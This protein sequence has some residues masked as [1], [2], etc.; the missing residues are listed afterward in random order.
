VTELVQRY[1]SGLLVELC[2][3]DRECEVEG[4]ADDAGCLQEHAGILRQPRHL[5]A[6]RCPDGRWNGHAIAVG[7]L[8]RVVPFA[9]PHASSRQLDQ[10]Q[11]VAAGLAVQGRPFAGLD[12]VAEQLRSVPLRQWLELE[13]ADPVLPCGR[14]R[15]VEQ[16]LRGVPWAIRVDQQQRLGDP[17]AKQVPQELERRWIRPVHVVEGEQQRLLRRQQPQRPVHGPVQ[18]KALEL[19]AVRGRLPGA[20]QRGEGRAELGHELLAEIRE[21]I[22]LALSEHAVERLDEDAERHA[23]LE[24]GPL[25]AENRESGMLGPLA[26]HLDQCR[27]ADSRLADQCHPTEGIPVGDRCRG[28]IDLVELGLPA[29]E[30]AAGG[31]RLHWSLHR[32]THSE[33]AS[34]SHRGFRRGRRSDRSSK[35]EDLESRYFRPIGLG[36]RPEVSVR[37]QLVFVSLSLTVALAA[38]GPH[39]A[40]AVDSSRPDR[41]VGNG[42]PQSCTS[43][44]V[45]RAVAKGGVIRFRCGPDPV[46]I[47]L[48]QTAKVVNTSRRV[49]L[50]GRGLVTLSGGGK[51][52]ILYQNTCDKRQ[53]WTTSHCDDQATPR[54]VVQNLTFA[55]GN[56]SGET[57][58]GGG[59][60]A[61]FARGGRLKIVRSTFVG[62]RCDATG[63]DLGGAAVRALSQYRGQPVTV[64]GSTFRGGVC[65]NGGAL[66]SI[67]VSWSIDDSVFTANRAIGRGA[68]PARPGAPGGGSGGALYADGNDFRILISRTTM[69]GNHAR[70]GGGA[71]FFVSNDRTGIL[72]IRSSTLRRNPSDGFETRPGI[73]FLGRDQRVVDSIVK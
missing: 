29:D 73:F 63:P 11:R 23:G 30:R 68:N 31:V 1:Q 66:S 9:V 72:D 19:Q 61:I 70:E 52:R 40:H 35:R 60:G 58:D 44:A 27:L 18:A 55:D 17:V 20:V 5:T 10:V 12:V 54:L 65:S 43:R 15:R 34:A 71:I 22:L 39:Q 42:T 8:R 6:D 48:R 56:A 67:G 62:N 28:A 41:W 2:D 53:T 24:L 45:V 50:D 69:T 64:I 7:S 37:L 25:A 13:R 21:E 46:R 14:G 26:R 32:A 59:G 51:R 33:Q 36:C 49:V 16:P 57:V 47:E 4:F 3:A 38:A